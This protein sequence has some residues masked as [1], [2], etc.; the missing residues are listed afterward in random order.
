MALPIACIPIII[1]ALSVFRLPACTAVTSSIGS[2]SGSNTDL[3]ALLAFKARLSDPLDILGTNWT[4]KTSFCQWLGVSCS[5][6]HRQRVATL[7]LPDMPLHGDVAPHLGN[8]SF[9]VVLNLTNTGLTGIIPPE[10]GRLHRLRYLGLRNNALSGVIPPT[11]GNLT[12]LQ[13][14]V[15]SNNSIS[16]QIPEELQGLRN[17]SL[18]GMI[19]R[20]IGSLP[21]LQSLGLQANQL[22]GS[23]PQAIFN[24]STLQLLYLGGNNLT[25]PIPSNKSFSLPML[26]IIALSSNRFT[27]KIPLGLAECQYLEVLSLSS[28]SFEGRVPTWLAKLPELAL[29]YL[30]ANNLDGPVPAVLS[31]L[32]NLVQLDLSFGNLTGGI[33]REFGQL[34]QLT[35]LSLSHNQL[36]GSFPSFASNLSELSFLLLDG[37]LLTGFVPMTLGSTGNLL[38]VILSGNHLEGNLNFLASLSNCRQLYQLDIGLNHFTGRIPNFIG[39]LSSALKLFFADRNNL[40]GELPATISNLSSLTW[41][42]FSENQLSSPIPKSIMMMDK[43]VFMYLYGNRLSGPIPAQLGVLG[44]LERLILLDNQLSGSIPDELGNLS[45]LVYLD[46]SQ[47]LLSSTIPVSLFHL[48]SVAQ[49]DLYQ[50]SLNGALPDG[51]GM[52]QQI[53][54]IDLSSNNF[55]GSLPS[56]FGQLRTLTDLNLSHNSLNGSIPDSFGNL[57]SLKSLDLSYNDLYSTIPGYLAKFTDLTCLNL[58]FNKLHGQIP[59]GG[60]FTNITLQSLIGNSAL[61]GVSRLGFLPCRSNYHSANNRRILKFLILGIII[62]VGTVVTCLYMIIRKKLKNQNMAV[63][64]GMVDMNNHNRLVSYHEIVRATCNFSETNLLGAGS[65]GKVYKGQLSDGLVVAIKVLNMQLEQ[66]IRSFDAECRVLRMARHRNL[67]RILTTCSNMEFKALV[68]PYMPNGSLETYLHTESRQCLGL[69]KRLDILLDVSIA[70][71]YLHCQHCEVVLHCDLKPSNILLDENMTPHVADFGI[72][73]LLYGDENSAASVSMPGTI[74]YMA[75]EYGSN[76]K[77]TIK[78]DVFSYGIMLLEVFTGKK[79]TDSM[80]VGEL[81]LR[82]WVN[83]AFPKSLIDIVDQRLLQDLSSC[84]DNFLVPMFELGLLCS[85]DI[86]DE[87]LTMSEVIVILNQIK[88]DYVCSIPK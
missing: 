48:E 64:T 43:L 10:L 38:S 11:M 74:G 76:G 82:Q 40:T 9:L 17:L 29:I 81:S 1:I 84:V 65:F 52:L 77:A 61:C 8:L 4:T 19:P 14:L 57:T 87:R 16:G 75:P 42:D 31:N 2:G 22:S 46:L 55:L 62:S 60:V 30:G 85:S 35:V 45:N 24:M 15:L 56:S 20:C 18:S 3:S 83:Q 33:P 73:K 28:N 49:L 78:S 36:T 88:K 26:E 70:M 5:H 69:L 54:S 71:E 63:S 6:R 67:I 34:S 58:S 47:N 12:S 21:V 53:I 44:N 86:P 59:G 23:V 39:N 13:F 66:A 32:T 50:N 25:G 51:I 7:V 79:P 68:L 41:I 80:F 37:N 27:G 72:A